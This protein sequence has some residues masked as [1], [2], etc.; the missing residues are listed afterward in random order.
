MRRVFFL[1]IALIFSVSSSFF[2][3]TSVNP[4][5]LAAEKKSNINCSSSI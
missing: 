4:L 1:I 2:F 3:G 5:L